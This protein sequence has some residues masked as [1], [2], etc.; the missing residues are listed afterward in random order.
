MTCR[1]AANYAQRRGVGGGRILWRALLPAL[2]AALIACPG[3]RAEEEQPESFQWEWKA[4]GQDAA[5]EPR[6]LGTEAVSKEPGAQG[7]GFSWSWEE[8]GRAEVS[9]MEQAGRG[10]N[11]EAYNELLR[12]NLNLRR[13]LAQA[14]E[15]RAAI[16][17]ENRRLRKEIADLEQR[18]AELAAVRRDLEKEMGAPAAAPDRVAEIREQLAQ[19]ERDKQTL[20]ERVTRLQRRV[21]DLERVTDVPR[22]TAGPPPGMPAPEPG[23]ALFRELQLENAELKEKLVELDRIRKQ[24]TQALARALQED[25]VAAQDAESLRDA[26]AQSKA[27]Q[28]QQR[29]VIA[30]IAHMVPRL[31]RELD[32]KDRELEAMQLELER[33][34]HRVTKA[35]R[36]VSLL[37]RVRDEVAAVED[38]EDRDMHF[39]MGLIYMREGQAKAAE[40]EYLRAMA[41][42]P[43]DPGVHYNLAILYDDELKDRDRAL[44]HYRKYLKLSP[45]APD[46]DQVK[47][48]ILD[49][50]TDLT[51]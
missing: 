14:G 43:A 15:G 17:R 40:Q 12:E 3:V 37:D 21:A 36:M 22:E 6:N 48:W 7:E 2:T 23:S 27:A 47:H 13:Q 44:L 9:E 29:K 49:L 26:L 10:I 41:I 25:R 20:T 30:K 39:N 38:G 46:R 4:G 16:D 8:E 50:E 45:H 31:E 11:A 5:G 35:R 24:E 18:L 33:R 28:K 34:E 1:Y 51:R 19:A 32:A 42:D